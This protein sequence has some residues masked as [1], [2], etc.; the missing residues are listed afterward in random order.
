MNFISFFFHLGNLTGVEALIAEGV[1]IE[2]K[3]ASMLNMR[4][5]H[6]AAFNSEPLIVYIAFFLFLIGASFIVFSSDHDDI[7]RTLIEHGADVNAVDTEKWT[8]LHFA[9]EKCNF[10]IHSMSKCVLTGNQVD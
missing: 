10:S 3:N 6:Y 8:P 4:P 5:L 1:N 2:A 7:V 9:I